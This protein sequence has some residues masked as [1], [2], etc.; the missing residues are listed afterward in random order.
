VAAIESTTKAWV[1][2]DTD[3]N[4]HERKPDYE[5]RNTHLSCPKSLNKATGTGQEREPS[6]SGQE[7]PGDA[8]ISSET[9]SA[10]RILEGLSDVLTGY[11]KPPNKNYTAPE[12][13]GWSVGS[14]GSVVPFEFRLLRSLRCGVSRL[15][16][17][18]HVESRH[19]QRV[20]DRCD[21]V[22]RRYR[23]IPD[24]PSIGTWKRRSR[25]I[26]CDPGTLCEGFRSVPFGDILIPCYGAKR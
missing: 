26:A 15:C 21:T 24:R 16:G 4:E 12:R 8:Y 5:K 10:R 2:E 19:C 20:A 11:V 7:S 17:R 6:E 13:V 14:R 18:P 22:S 3:A 25:G 9:V 1:D 23:C